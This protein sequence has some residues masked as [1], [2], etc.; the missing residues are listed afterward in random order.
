MHIAAMKVA[1]RCRRRSPGRAGREGRKIAAEKAAE[2]RQAGRDR[3]Q[4]GRRLGKKFLKEV[5][6]LD[7]VFVKPPTASRPWCQT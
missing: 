6:L 5:S 7:Q 2:S 1:P 3:R 4:D